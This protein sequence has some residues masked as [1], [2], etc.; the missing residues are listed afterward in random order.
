MLWTGTRIPHYALVH[1]LRLRVQALLAA[2]LASGPHAHVHAHLH[3]GR[4]LLH[5][6][7][8]WVR[9]ITHVWIRRRVIEL[10]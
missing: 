5:G 9:I 8:I 4:R 1:S 6:I 10:R 2:I 3:H 7:R